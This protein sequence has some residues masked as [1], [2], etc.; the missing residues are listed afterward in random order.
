[1]NM[2]T[3]TVC[4]TYIPRFSSQICLSFFTF[5]LF[6]C[7][8][9]WYLHW[10]FHFISSFHFSLLHLSNFD[11]AKTA[12]NVRETCATCA[13]YP[14]AHIT[15]M[16]L[17]ALN[18]ML[19]HAYVN[20]ACLFRCLQTARVRLSPVCTSA[21]ANGWAYACDS[22]RATEDTCRLC[23]ISASLHFRFGRISRWHI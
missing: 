16:S 11:G 22:I 18:L 21:I 9:F 2:C 4:T 13:E 14:Q 6:R 5:L 10:H 3:V 8:T 17:H 19:M 20:A 1:M 12:R 7:V 15:Y 23:V